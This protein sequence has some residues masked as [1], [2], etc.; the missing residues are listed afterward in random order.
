[1]RFDGVQR[2]YGMGMARLESAHVCVVGLGGVGSWAVEAL[3]RSGVGTLTMADPDAV[4]VSNVNRQI[5]AL[6]PHIGRL[7]VDVLAERIQA[8]APECRVH[9]VAQFINEET[10]PSLL[11]AGF[12][13]VIDAIDGVMPKAGL[14]AGC[15]RAGIPVIS[16]GGSGGKSDPAAIR[17]VDLAQTYNDRLL[18]FVRKKL[19]HVFQFPATGPFSVPCVF[20]PEPVACPLS[21]TPPPSDNPL[22]AEAGSRLNCDG[23]LGALTFVTGTFGFRAA[24][25][26]VHSLA[27]T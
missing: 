19:R 3:A 8:I 7:K 2:I 23:R 20:S 1:M 9:R 6:D 18:A 13:Y 14:I 27:K 17:V 10:M 25:E 15:R 5:Q 16:C 21:C 4:C 12:D 11:A 22:L 24:A 26:V